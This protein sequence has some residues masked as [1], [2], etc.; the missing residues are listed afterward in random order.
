[1]IHILT[2][3]FFPNGPLWS[4]GL[5]HVHYFLPY[6]DY[7][8]AVTISNNYLTQLYRQMVRISLIRQWNGF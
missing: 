6:T 4:T 3:I 5:Q 1:M 8:A 7:T 2:F